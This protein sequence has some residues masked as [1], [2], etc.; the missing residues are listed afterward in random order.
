MRARE[1][2]SFDAEQALGVLRRSL[3]DDPFVRWL[4]RDDERA[5]ETYL[6]LM[7]ERIALPKGLVHV[8]EHGARDA[9]V[10]DDAAVHDDAPVGGS[11][12][13]E[14]GVIPGASAHDPERR[15]AAVALWAPPFTFELSALETLRILPAMIGVIGAMRFARVS[16]ALAEV[17]QARPP[18]PRW[19]L[20]LLG[21]EPDL[22]GRGYASVALAPALARCDEEG[23]VAVCETSRRENLAFYARHGFSVVSERVLGPDGPPSFTLRR[24]PRVLAPHARG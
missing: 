16:A 19:L 3:S 15:L 18:E 20:T 11:P 8:V 7:L 5:I 6:R 1:A 24:A 13:I 12:P 17:E 9:A 14:E 22:R 21:T 4:A 2:T 23:A 10:D